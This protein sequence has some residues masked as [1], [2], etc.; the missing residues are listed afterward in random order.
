MATGQYHSGLSILSKELER[1]ISHKILAH[2]AAHN[3]LSLQQW[4]FQRGKCT[5][6]ALIHITDHWL[7]EIGKNLEIYICAVFFNLQK[8]FDSVPHHALAAT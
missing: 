1:H 3:S 7:H 5:T 8:A 2:L 4:G 6:T